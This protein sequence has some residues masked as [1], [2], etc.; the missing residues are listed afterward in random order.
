MAE[1]LS[2]APVLDEIIERAN[3][4]RVPL[5]RVSRERL[6][7][8]ATTAAP[9][10]VLARA[11]P[12]T[13]AD[14]DDL[15]GVRPGAAEG[16]PRPFLLALDGVTDPQ[17]LG[18]LLRSAEAAGVTG[19]VLPRHRSARI[20]PTVAKA[21]AGAVES[22]P[23][24]LVAGIPGALSRA[25]DCGCWVVGLAADA[26]SSLFDLV[27]AT[28]PVVVVVGAEGQGLSRLARQRCD[29]VVRIPMHGAV[30]SLNVAA[31]GALALFEVQRRRSGTGAPLE[32]P[33]DTPPAPG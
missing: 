27:V 10:G 8:Q 7:T 17:N 25:R 19:V 28:E 6:E 29:L 3:R 16:A 23:V 15:L 21:A 13:Q 32:T 14:L 26:Q 33:I 2:P 18:A 11:D 5:R 4:Q 9:Q 1:G 22:I 30:A 24:A 20:T 12:L 31:A